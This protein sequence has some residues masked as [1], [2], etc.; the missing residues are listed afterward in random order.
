MGLLERLLE[1]VLTEHA[2]AYLS[3]NREQLRVGVRA[4]G[5]QVNSPDDAAAGLCNFAF[6]GVEGALLVEALD[7]A[8]FAVSTGAACSSGSVKPSPVL[9]AV[10]QD[11]A[12]A[13]RG[14]RVSLGGDASEADV[15]ALLAAL[16]V[17]V[18]RI[19]AA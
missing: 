10:G 8:G 5:A 17:L 12:R 2:G 18:P 3:V 11:A 6:D 7:L 16:V 4:L 15:G 19:R 9:L 14:V 1:R 13:K